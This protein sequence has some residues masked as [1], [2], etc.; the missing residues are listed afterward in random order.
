MNF[1]GN[2]KF[3]DKILSIQKNRKIFTCSLIRKNIGIIYNNNLV[4]SE[5]DDTVQSAGVG[6]YN[7]IGD[8]SSLY[9]LWA[10]IGAK[11]HLGSGIA[12][13]YDESSEF[14]GEYNVRYFVQNHDRG[15]FLVKIGRAEN[16]SIYKLSWYKDNANVLHGIG[17]LIENSLAFA[18][19]SINCKF[20]FSRFHYCVDS[21][22]ERLKRQTII[23]DSVKIES[24]DYVRV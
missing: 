9:A 3:D 2:W 19:G 16:E 10:S 13:K 20:D 7:Q 1:C 11:G 17:F 4:V 12:L 21:G 8:G 23:W 24:N 6:V 5:F 18:W 22:I 15:S 14:D